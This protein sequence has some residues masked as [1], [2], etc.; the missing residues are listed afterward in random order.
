MEIAD[1]ALQLRAPLQQLPVFAAQ[2]IDDP[3]KA[4][5]ER[6]GIDLQER[7]QFLFDEVSQNGLDGQAGGVT[8]CIHGSVSVRWGAGAQVNRTIAPWPDRSMIW[9]RPM[10]NS[11]PSARHGTGAGRRS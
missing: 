5:P 3:A 7:Q 9:C 2:L 10:A 1:P 11:R 4:S 8:G 6:G